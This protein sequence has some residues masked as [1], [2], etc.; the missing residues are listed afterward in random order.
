MLLNKEHRVKLIVL[1]K[2]IAW[3]SNKAVH[4]IVSAPYIGKNIFPLNLTNPEPVFCSVL[5]FTH[6]Q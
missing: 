3:V 1:D 6:I 2:S 4:T 5:S